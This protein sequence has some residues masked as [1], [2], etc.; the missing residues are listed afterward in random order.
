MIT[1]PS[2]GVKKKQTSRVGS[3]DANTPLITI[4]RKGS[5]WPRFYL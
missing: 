1:D 5:R 2:Y 4:R 3:Q